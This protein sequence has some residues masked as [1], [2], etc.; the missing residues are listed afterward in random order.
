MKYTVPLLYLNDDGPAGRQYFDSFL[1]DP[2]AFV[3]KIPG[4]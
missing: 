1:R 4:L 2:R 3:A